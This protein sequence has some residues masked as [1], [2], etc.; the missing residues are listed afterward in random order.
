[1]GAI[2]QNAT[3]SA[4]ALINTNASAN[5]LSG[6]IARR[7]SDF[8]NA[9]NGNTTNVNALNILQNQLNFDANNQPNAA[10][11]TTSIV[12]STGAITN[13]ANLLNR[14]DNVGNALGASSVALSGIGNISSALR[15]LQGIIESARNATDTQRSLLANR[16]SDIL[17]AISSNLNSTRFNNIN[18]L[19]NDNDITV[20]FGTT[21]NGRDDTVVVDGLDLANN[22]FNGNNSLFSVAAFTTANVINFSA[23][24]TT[25][26]GITGLN[27]TN[28]TDIDSAVAR[29]ESSI[30]RLQSFASN[31]IIS[32][33]LIQ[34]RFTSIVNQSPQAS[35][36][37]NPLIVNFGDS[38]IA[39]VLN[40]S[41]RFV[42]S[43]NF[44]QA[45]TSNTLDIL[46]GRVALR[47]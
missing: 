31:F 23:I 34:E 4:N 17:Q 2:S 33:S 9:D 3:Q 43:V 46:G 41:R 12:S 1:M 45:S 6:I 39:N 42:S 38:R 32:S 7:S 10:P 11:N 22:V 28:I 25:A 44:V 37:P 13:N 36:P 40:A 20:N 47:V 19:V 21:A 8:F 24:F 35:E 15:N 18:L 29:I 5:T 26:N 30:N 27:S 14:Q 16:T